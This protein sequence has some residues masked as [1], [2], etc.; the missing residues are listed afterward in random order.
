MH[1]SALFVYPVKSLRGCAV[2]SVEIDSLGPVGDRRFMVVDA[3]GRFLTQRTLPR[4]ALIGT[5]LAADTL[6]LSAE[7]AAP[8]DVPRRSQADAPL[9]SVSVWQSEGLK[10]EDCGEPAATW[11]QAVLGCVCRLVRIGPAFRRPVR[12]LPADF[13][14]AATPL[15]SFADGYPFLV[16][17]EASLADLN[18]R[19]AGHGEDPLPVDRFRP[20]LVIAGG[21]PYAE[22]AWPR[23]RL[24]EVVFRNAGPC[25]RCA[26][27]T[28][29]QST[30]QR[31][32]E[33]L[34]TLA[35][36]RRDAADPTNVNFG[37]NLIAEAPGGVL[38]VGDPVEF[39]D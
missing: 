6:T 39:L 32:R 24:G 30:A 37:R 38:R 20:N 1:L 2:A 10:A 5:A 18:D 19:L 4:M 7:G 35:T 25:A 14:P 31:G 11:L 12:K 3:T 34:R 27:T 22:D 33:P 36:Y 8:L 16:L 17:G 9:R 15:V 21:T 29:D 13:G 28:T 23:F 26:I